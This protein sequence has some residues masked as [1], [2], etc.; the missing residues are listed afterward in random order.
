MRVAGTAIGFALVGLAVWAIARDERVWGAV[1]EVFALGQDGHLRGLVVLGGLCAVTFVFI[2]MAFW[3]LTVRYGAVGK[4]EMLALILAAGVLNFLPMWP[5][6]VGRLAYHKKVN[7]IAV[8]ESARVIIWANVVS[9]VGAVVLAGA[10]VPIALLGD[11]SLWVVHGTTGGLLGG[12]VLLAAFARGK[13]PEP[14]PEVWR[15]LAAL[16]IRYAE[17]F[18]WTGR[19]MICFGLVGSEISWA[20]ALALAAVTRL[21]VMIPIAPNGVGVREWSVGL[22]GPMLPVAMTGSVIDIPT[23]LA[24]D[25]VNRAVE[26]LIAVPSGVVSAGWLA[27]RMRGKG[28]EVGEREVEKAEIREKMERGEPSPVITEDRDDILSQRERE[29]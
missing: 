28:G 17:L 18:V 23:A 6:M 11:A 3:V 27:K 20:G 1:G 25:V 16:S 7:G 10:L 29:H 9:L 8:R 26:V 14:E 21:A 5:G 13:R 19:Y 24:A 12:M 4:G 22:I 2:S 15:M